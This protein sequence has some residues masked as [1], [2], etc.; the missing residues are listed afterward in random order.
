ALSARGWA[1][2]DESQDAGQ[3]P[4]MMSI[5]DRIS[6][7]F[8][9]VRRPTCSVSRALSS[10]TICE[11]FATDSLGSPVALCDSSTLPGAFAHFTLLVSGT[12]TTVAMRLLLM[13][14]PCTTTRGRRKPGPEPMG[15]GRSA[16]HTSPRAITTPYAQES[17]E[18]H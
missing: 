12:H 2:C 1:F 11:T 17:C 4:R 8:A 5:P 3:R 9:L 13:A 15:S 6:S 18:L 16:H 7:T 14:S 10:A